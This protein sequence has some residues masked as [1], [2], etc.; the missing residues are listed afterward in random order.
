MSRAG[1]IA[2]GQGTS[3]QLFRRKE[4]CHGVR[5]ARLAPRFLAPGTLGLTQNPELDGLEE[6]WPTASPSPTHG[7]ATP[8][9]EGVGGG[10]TAKEKWVWGGGCGC[11]SGCVVRGWGARSWR[12][13][14]AGKALLWGRG[15]AARLE[16]CAPIPAP[17]PLLRMLLLPVTLGTAGPLL[18]SGISFSPSGGGWV[19]GAWRGNLSLGEGGARSGVIYL[20]H[21]CRGCPGLCLISPW[22]L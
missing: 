19:S 1:T 10:A 8:W 7:P 2:Q 6:P 22:L 18:A 15:A 3:Q 5:G 21:H 9:Q 16:D 11:E 13:V 12:G 14:R 4:G 17:S 20:S